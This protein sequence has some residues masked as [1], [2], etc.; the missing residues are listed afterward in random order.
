M[1]HH[2][3]LR[4]DR[5]SFSLILL[6]NHNSRTVHLSAIPFTTRTTQLST[7]MKTL[8]AVSAGNSA[9]SSAGGAA[10]SA[11]SSASGNFAPMVTVAANGLVGVA[12]LAAVMLL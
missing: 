2:S 11:A 3:S 12:G 5:L 1:G 10:S 9:T 7:I 6:L 4:L 8:A